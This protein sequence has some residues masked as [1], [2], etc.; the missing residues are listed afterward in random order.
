MNEEEQKA[1]YA[2]LLLEHKD[3]FRAAL[4][5][6]P[7]P[8]FPVQKSLRVATEW[9][10][11]PTVLTLITKLKAKGADIDMLPGKADFARRIWDLSQVAIEDK[12]KIAALK[13]YGETRG[14]IEKPN[15]NVNVAVNNNKVM[16]IRD[17]GSNADW[18]AKAEKQQRNL[19]N[20]SRSRH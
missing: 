16:V 2:A 4:I 11:D 8:Q 20:V 6:F 15:T 1:A 7:T 13:L 14:Y 19:L 12:D 3:P 5:L 18:E 9:P 17:Q 10:H